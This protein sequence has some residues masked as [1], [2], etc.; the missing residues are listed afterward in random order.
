[1]R[2]L[3]LE[4]SAFGPYTGEQ[5]IDFEQ[6]GAK[7]LYLITGDTGAGKT[8]IFDAISYALYDC[9]SCKY[10]NSSQFRS[11]NADPERETYVRLTFSYRGETYVI[12]RSPSYD[13]PKKRGNGTTNHLAK[14]EFHLSNGKILTKSGEVK[15]AVEE[16]IGLT[17]EQ[18]SRIMMIAQG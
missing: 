11:Q 15:A 9:A 10:R 14:V 12:F 16:V 18:F 4:L 8:T 3:K 7:G 6:I 5:V 2:P 17:Q 13:R 1:M